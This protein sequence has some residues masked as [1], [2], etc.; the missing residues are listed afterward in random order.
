MTSKKR[1]AII[2]LSP[3]LQSNHCMFRIRNRLLG[4]THNAEKKREL[5]NLYSL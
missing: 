5:F 4:S 3:E 1:T 2:P